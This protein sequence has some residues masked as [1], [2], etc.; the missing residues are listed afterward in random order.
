MVGKGGKQN[1]YM[2]VV[3]YTCSVTNS[4]DGTN[5]EIQDVF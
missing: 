4:L 2:L 3:N 1:E 5:G